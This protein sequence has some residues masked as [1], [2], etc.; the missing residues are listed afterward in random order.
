[1]RMVPLGDLM[2]SKRATL[3]PAKSPDERFELFSIPAFDRGEPEIVQGC[4]IGSAK[5]VVEPGD[6]LI[7][8]IVPHIRRAMFVPEARNLTQLASSEWISFRSHEVFPA[9]L[10]HYL[11]SD[12][13]HRQFMN[14]VAGVGGSLLRA[15]PAQ[16]KSILAPLP[17]LTEQRRIAAI[18]DKADSI[19]QKRRQALAHLDTLTQSIFHELMGPGAALTRFTFNEVIESIG[20]GSSPKC[21]R[22]PA[23][24]GEWG[25]LKL[26][27]VTTGKFLPA[28]NKAHI[29]DPALISRFEVRAGDLLMTRKNTPELVGAAALVESTPPK[30]TIP[31]IVFRIAPN[32]QLV[33]GRFLHTLLMS[34]RVRD[35]VRALAGGSAKSMSNISMAKLKTL[36]IAI[37]DLATQKAFDFKVD[38]I[39]ARRNHAQESASSADALFASLQSQAFRGEL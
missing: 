9:Y 1:M 24:S 26:S 15:R 3:N 6:V 16:V 20:T 10:T 29:G 7:S 35:Q 39:V 37:P 2:P 12:G 23:E 32:R 4:E 19:R 18:L 30:L 17:P 13:F 28:E 38:A 21:E 14:T 11:T 25:V 34:P 31:D 5:Q 27:A 33:T 22:R 36:A 8:K